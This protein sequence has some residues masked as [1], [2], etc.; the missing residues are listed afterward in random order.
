MP[1]EKGNIHSLYIIGYTY[2][3]YYTSFI[4]GITIYSPTLIIPETL[5]FTP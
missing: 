1:A 5:P 3:I 4:R 2:H